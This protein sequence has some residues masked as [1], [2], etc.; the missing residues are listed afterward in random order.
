MRDFKIAFLLPVYFGSN[1]SIFLGVGY[2]VSA[3]KS[4]GDDALVID[5][6]AVH[7]IYF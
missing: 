4:K 6:D 3:V 5:E 7:W 1:H 2:L